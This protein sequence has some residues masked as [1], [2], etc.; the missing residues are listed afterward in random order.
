MGGIHRWIRFADREVGT[1]EGMLRVAAQVIQRAGVIQKAEEDLDPTNDVCRTR[2]MG[3]CYEQTIVDKEACAPLITVTKDETDSATGHPTRAAISR[4]H[5]PE[6]T[7]DPPKSRFVAPTGPAGRR[8]G[9]GRRGEKTGKQGVRPDLAHLEM[10]A[11]E[12]RHH[13]KKQR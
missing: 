6:I 3:V 8:R 13:P 5:H 1:T 11:Y 12:G 7:H 10:A 2:A 9:H 4:C